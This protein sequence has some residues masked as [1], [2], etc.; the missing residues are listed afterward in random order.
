MQ[1]PFLLPLL[2]GGT[3]ELQAHDNCQPLKAKPSYHG[4][5]TTTRVTL[6]LNEA[7]PAG[8]TVSAARYKTAISVQ[9][10]S[11]EFGR[12]TTR[13][14]ALPRGLAK[15][16]IERIANRVRIEGGQLTGQPIEAIPEASSGRATK[17]FNNIAVALNSPS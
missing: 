17:T 15:P 8:L 6:P 10:P 2:C 1:C 13:Q 5:H 4:A 9:P 3:G 11:D 12:R 14:A 16:L 7:W